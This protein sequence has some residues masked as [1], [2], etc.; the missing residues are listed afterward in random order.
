MGV[1]R[2]TVSRHLDPELAPVQER[3]VH[4]VHRVFSVPFVVETNEREAPA[5]LCVAVPRDVD[6]PDPAVLLE[7]V[8]EGFG[9]SSVGQVVHFEGSHAVDVRRGPAETHAGYNPGGRAAFTKTP[10]EITRIDKNCF[11]ILLEHKL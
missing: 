8:S 10:L 3:S 4:G 1:G 5:L 2:S 7:H 11:K 6:V 9:G